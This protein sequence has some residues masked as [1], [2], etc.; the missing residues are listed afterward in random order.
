MANECIPLY[1]PGFDVSVHAAAGVE[2]CRFVEVVGLE[3][4]LPAVRTCPAG[5]V[6]F[7]VAVRD[8]DP[9]SSRVTV[10]RGPNVVAP[11][12][13][14]GRIA[15]G[16]L[17]EVGAAGAAV[18]ASGG[19]PVVG[20]A[21][22]PGTPGQLVYVDLWG[23]NISGVDGDGL[24]G[25]VTPGGGGEDLQGLI[26]ILGG[27]PQG[28]ASLADVAATFAALGQALIGAV[29]IEEAAVNALIQAAL[30]DLDLSGVGGGLDEDAVNALIEAALAGVGPVI[31][32]AVQSQVGKVSDRLTIHS[33]RA[34][35]GAVV[36]ET[37]NLT[38]AQHKVGINF[39]TQRGGEITI[40]DKR[41]LTVDDILE[42]GLSEAEVN[43]LIQAALGNLPDVGGLTPE[44]AAQ[45]AT[46]AT[47][48]QVLFNALTG[49]DGANANMAGA[50]M[51]SIREGLRILDG[52]LDTTYD[53]LIRVINDINGEI[54]IGDAAI[55][56][57]GPALDKMRAESAKTQAFLNAI[58][59][60]VAGWDGNGTPPTAQQAADNL[61]S[62]IIDLQT[63]FDSLEEI[64]KN[65][66]VLE[67]LQELAAGSG[68]GATDLT[69]VL[70]RL[71]ALEAENA[72]LKAKIKELDEGV[73]AA[74]DDVVNVQFPAVQQTMAD[75][76]EYL[77]E[78]YAEKTAV[79]QVADFAQSIIDAMN[80]PGA[81]IGPGTPNAITDMF[82]LLNDVIMAL[83]EATGIEF[84]AAAK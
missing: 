76:V 29:G 11:V 21:L 81:T 6:A 16:S 78:T 49:F 53:Y 8:S 9:R 80:G 32:Q 68:S 61:A 54:L 45:L 22:E 75:I 72:A 17:V 25:V 28:G 56:G 26:D 36:I 19:A 55:D 4:N 30:A 3:A 33:T 40:D 77:V 58:Y 51:E 41:V 5:G 37:N 18:A 70:A 14:G 60:H 1:R 71:D 42:A 27:K 57:V 79:Q 83:V 24:G 38:G 39:K 65:G 84:P 13:A 23:S 15:A 64:V 66:Q 46:N 7:G 67:V 50:A 48:L 63:N 35:D 44:Q 52:S 69:G 10:M 82:W 12:V 34:G 73:A 43:A 20:R 59:K 62:A 74:F 2:G 47:N 31:M